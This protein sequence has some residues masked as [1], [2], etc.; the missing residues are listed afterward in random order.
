MPGA[1]GHGIDEGFQAGQEGRI[2]RGGRLAAYAVTADPIRAGFEVRR[3]GG[4]LHLPQPE[5]DGR[6]RE[7]G[8]EGDGGSAGVIAPKYS[9][10]ARSASHYPRER[11]RLAAKLVLAIVYKN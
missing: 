2:V 1:P 4:L 3:F 6:L 10:Q 9:T 11:R 5:T 7:S 8:G